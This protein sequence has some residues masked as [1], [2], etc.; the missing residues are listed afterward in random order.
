MKLFII[1]ASLTF[2]ILNS[3]YGENLAVQLSTSNSVIQAANIADPDAIVVVSSRCPSTHVDIG[4]DVGGRAET[5]IYCL[6]NAVFSDV[7]PERY[8]SSSDTCAD[9]Y[10]VAGSVSN[11]G[12]ADREYICARDQFNN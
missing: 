3:A 5:R 11:R 8:Y 9:G 7:D 2:I 12:Y 4:E 6:K 10:S 1:L